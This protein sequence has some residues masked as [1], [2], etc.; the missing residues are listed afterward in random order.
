MIENCI[1]YLGFWILN[2]CIDIETKKIIS[3]EYLIR[4]I[5]SFMQCFLD[6]LDI[7]L[8]RWISLQ[9][10]TAFFVGQNLNA[11]NYTYFWNG[12]SII[13]NLWTQFN[14]A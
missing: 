10:K 9:A 1:I 2:E 8:I 5:R 3:T 11:K 6:L 13:Y 14:K 4:S 7:A 12:G